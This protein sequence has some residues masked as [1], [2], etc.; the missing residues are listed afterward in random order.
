[1][2]Y[3]L[4]KRITFGGEEV[5]AFIAEVPKSIKPKR[6]TLVTQIAGSNREVVEMEDAWESYDQTYTLFVGDG[7]EDSVRG[8]IDEV[9]RVLS[10]TGYQVLTDDYDPDH[11]R[12][13]YFDSQVSI[14]NRY[15][16]LGKFDV[17]FHCRPEKFLV[18]GNTPMGV[19]NNGTLFNPT[20]FASKP[21]IRI[22]GSG[23][24]TLTVAGVTMAFTGISDYLNIDCEK[25]NVYRLPAENRNN[26]M[27]GEFPV[28]KSG[29]NLIA[30]TGGISTVTITPKFW[31]L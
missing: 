26:L 19:A 16:R 2:A 1:M 3:E 29:E 21:L 11:Y 9:A 31:T 25:M 23:N 22:T 7:S 30:F 5:P 13:A 4:D 24:G 17:V 14:D 6:K 27:T 10:K 18:S 8:A 15:T 12:M 28:L 20:G